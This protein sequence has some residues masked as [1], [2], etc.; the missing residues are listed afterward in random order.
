MRELFF[1]APKLTKPPFEIFDDTDDKANVCRKYASEKKSMP[2]RETL[3]VYARNKGVQVSYGQVAG[4]IKDF[5]DKLLSGLVGTQITVKGLAPAHTGTMQ[6]CVTKNDR[7][8][9]EMA[10]SEGFKVTS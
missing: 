5:T 2:T 4:V 6:S 3:Q 10:S 1:Q 7:T 9:V 8:T